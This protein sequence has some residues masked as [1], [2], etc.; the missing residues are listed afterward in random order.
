MSEQD[1]R[2]YI[3][4]FIKSAKMYGY[5]DINEIKLALKRTAEAVWQVNK[6]VISPNDEPAVHQN[7]RNILEE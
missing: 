3:N 5:Q 7:L 2:E 4:D 1:K 6:F